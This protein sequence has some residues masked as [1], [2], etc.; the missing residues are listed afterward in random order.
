VTQGKMD[1]EQNKQKLLERIAELESQVFGLEKD[2]IHDAL[3]GLKT[4]AFFEEESK[5]YLDMINHISAGKRKQWFGFKNISFLFF[6][7]DH[8]KKI[9]DTFGHDVGDLV[10]KKVAQTIKQNMR[11]GDTV[12]RWGGEEMVASLLGADLNDAKLKAEDIRQKIEKLTFENSEIKVTISIGVVSSEISSDFTDLMKK[13]DQS[14]YQAK[15]SGRN[16][17]VGFDQK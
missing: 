16:K 13:A 6:D 5:V 2:L 17:V 10:L 15:Q 3:T 4:R 1:D 12:A 7:I 9:N 11:V 14:L 8:F